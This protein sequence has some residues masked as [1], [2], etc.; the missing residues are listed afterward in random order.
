MRGGEAAGLALDLEL[1]L[2]ADEHR[3]WGK[4]RVDG[5]LAL[6]HVAVDPH[7]HLHRE[8]RRALP[9]LLVRVVRGA[10]AL[11]HAPILDLGHPQREVHRDLP[12]PIGCHPGARVARP[13]VRLIPL[14]EADDALGGRGQ[15]REVVEAGA[16]RGVVRLPHEGEV[17]EERHRGREGEAQALGHLSGREAL[18][19]GEQRTR[20]V[21]APPRAHKRRASDRRPVRLG[22]RRRRGGA[23]LATVRSG[24]RAGA[25]RRL[26]LDIGTDG[27]EHELGLVRL[28][29]DLMQ[30]IIKAGTASTSRASAGRG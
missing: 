29:L 23:H 9:H 8:W 15:L 27:D 5:Q 7:A 21:G 1:L 10:G 12:A 24:R 14:H 2:A 17:A 13:A 4:V 19:V 20:L 6:G 11:L 26:D 25:P 22:W 3:A 28:V 30:Q 16:K 18:E